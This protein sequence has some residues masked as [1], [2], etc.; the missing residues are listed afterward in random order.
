VAAIRTLWREGPQSFAGRFFRWG[1]I[2]SNPKPVQR[3][4]VPIV[5]GGHTEIAARRAARYGDGFF[6]GLVDVDTLARLLAILREECARVGRR[7]EDVE[8]TYIAPSP[9]VDQVHRLRDAGVNRICIGPPGFDLDS[10]RAGL[11]RFTERVLTRV[12]G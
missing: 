10:V 2:E 12:G 7:A 3:P 6:P 11:E 9:D 5:V 4:G 8:L 1:P